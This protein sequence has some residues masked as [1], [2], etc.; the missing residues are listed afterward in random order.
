MK[1]KSLLL[2]IHPQYAERI[3]RSEKR[4]ELRRLRPRLTKGD[5]VVLYATSPCRA[6]VGT[7]TVGRLVEGAPA[8]LWSSVSGSCGVSRRRF[9]AYFSGARTGFAIEVGA[10]RRLEEPI[11]LPDIRVAV[12]EFR[13]PQ[14]YHYLRDDR[15]R[16]RTLHRMVSGG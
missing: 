5:T 16:D 9:D 4:F 11:P 1:G 3:F 10:V 8:S 14:G 7:F 12:P 6:I 2:S 15:P 13:P